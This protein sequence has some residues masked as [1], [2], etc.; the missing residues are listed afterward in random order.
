MSWCS[1]K[2]KNVQW[3]VEDIF[4]VEQIS[5]D[6]RQNLQSI[7]TYVPIRLREGREKSRIWKLVS[8]RLKYVL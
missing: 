6:S 4:G 5:G 1:S 7:D 8:E 2:K 3:L